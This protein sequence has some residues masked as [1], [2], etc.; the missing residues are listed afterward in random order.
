ML[1]CKELCKLSIDCS[2]KS[3]KYRFMYFIPFFK[4]QLAFC[5]Y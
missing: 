2:I 1:G 4:T 5:P 3:V